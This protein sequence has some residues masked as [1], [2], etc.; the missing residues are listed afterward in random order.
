MIIDCHCHAGRNAEFWRE[1]TLSEWLVTYMRQ[2][3]IAKITRTVLFAPLVKN[4]AHANRIVARIVRRFPT[5]FI[6][7]AF[8]DALRDSGHVMDM[9]LEAVELHQFR[10]IKCH[11]HDA[12]LS[13]EICE[14]AS[15]LN[16]PLLY[17][18]M[19]RISEID[20]AARDFPDVNFI[21]PHFGTFMD[22]WSVQQTFIERLVEFPNVYTDTSGVRRYDLIESAIR[23][24]GSKKVLF[25]SD[26]PW[27]HPGVELAKINLMH[28]SDEQRR[29]VLE[30]NLLRLIARVS[31]E[32]IALAA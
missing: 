14:A 6:G 29:D 12:P 30:G 8:V 31:E 23:R 13:D 32:N 25:G 4:Y 24:A 1:D 21:V 18:P 22:S 10:G 9:L 20:R 16:L 19:G 17:D 11:R 2:A 26:G 15:R 28:L 5:L 27:L 3:R 7:F